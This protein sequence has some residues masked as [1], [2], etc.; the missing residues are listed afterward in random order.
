MEHRLQRIVPVEDIALGLL[1][2]GIM[3][4]PRDERELVV[5]PLK[6]AIRLG[7]LHAIHGAL[8]IE[9]DTEGLADVFR[10]W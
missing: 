9:I 4:D 8:G 6:D 3:L 2:F 5:G 7:E 1:L 10:F